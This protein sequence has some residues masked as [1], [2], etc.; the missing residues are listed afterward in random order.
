MP[1]EREWSERDGESF[2]KL[3]SN[4]RERE[5]EGQRQDGNEKSSDERA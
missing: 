2:E 5:R 1:A 4:R 3:K